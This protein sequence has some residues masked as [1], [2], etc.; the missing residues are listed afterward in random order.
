MNLNTISYLFQA[1]LNSSSLLSTN[2]EYIA[3]EKAALQTKAAQLQ[4]KEHAR[5]QAKIEIIEDKL[6]AS[7]KADQLNKE[8]IKTLKAKVG[9]YQNRLN[10]TQADALY[11]KVK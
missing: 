6:E 7:K 1:K 4:V 5:L 10:I 2:L 3:K 9:D 8:E 11:T